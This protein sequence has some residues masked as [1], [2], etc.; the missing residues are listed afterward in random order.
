MFKDLIAHPL[1][2][3]LDL[4]D[5]RTTLLR[6]D[7][8]QQK[9]FLRR[10]YEEW[11]AALVAELSAL[12]GPLLEIGS[13]PG[14]L[15]E[16]LPSLITSEVFPLSGIR[17]AMDA[18]AFP[19]PDAV[20]G[21]VVGT[22]VLHHLK[23]VR[24]FLW[25][26][27]RCLRPKGVLV[28]IEPWVTPWSR[29]VFS[30][31]HHEPFEPEAAEWELPASGPLAG[32]NGALPWILFCR[33]RNQFEQEFPAWEIRSVQPIMPFRYLLSGGISLRFSMPGWSF[34]F[35]TLIERWLGRWNGQIAM[36]AKIVL[37][38]TVAA[39]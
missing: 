28:L 4:D 22:N 23:P 21:A 15:S 1:T 14:F 16:Y 7:I 32:V 13:G 27:S 33:D 31:F 36:F 34:P 30:C 35:W 39:P 12:P 20:L 24:R 18:T 25:E 6:K 38:R 11:Y 26:A 19:M 5:P 17:C 10:I 2:R 3:D 8:L 9:R 29:F 37:R